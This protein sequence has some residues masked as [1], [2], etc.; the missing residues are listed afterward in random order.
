MSDKARELLSKL[1][2]AKADVSFLETEYRKVCECNE[3]IPGV[4]FEP[5]SYSQMYK[6]CK[7]HEVRY[8]HHAE[9]QHHAHV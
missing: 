6:T 3:K 1:R 2:K 8:Y 4:K 5:H 9:R 7:Y